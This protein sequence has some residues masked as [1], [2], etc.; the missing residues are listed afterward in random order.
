MKKSFS[1]SGGFTLIEILLVITIIL[2]L[3][4]LTVGTA[5][6]A[7]LKGRRENAKVEIA[8][9]RAA[10]ESYKADNGDY[11]RDTYTN[12][13]NAKPIPPA[14]PPSTLISPSSATPCMLS[15]VTLYKAL[16]GDLNATGAYGTLNP[17]TGVK[18]TIYW[19]IR[20]SMLWPVCPVG[21][22][23]TKVTALV[24]P[25]KNVYGY[26]T[27][28]SDPASTDPATGALLKGY[29]PTYDIWSTADPDQTGIT[30]PASWISNWS[31]N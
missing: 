23:R 9:M 14:T 21:V 15:S 12:A 10:I 27:I 1:K 3:A 5:Q 22:A 4:A 20:P 28:G 16:T 30:V 13:I 26:S 11:P 8:S 7:I 19:S 18:Q 31:N 17:S 6:W 2:A 29:N 25:F 24:D